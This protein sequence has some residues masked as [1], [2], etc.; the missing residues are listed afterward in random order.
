[1]LVVYTDVYN[2]IFLLV[3]FHTVVTKPCSLFSTQTNQYSSPQNLFVGNYNN[4]YN[5]PQN[6]LERALKLLHKI[7]R[8]VSLMY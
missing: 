5:V 6:I 7:K 3:T 2:L 8:N 1:M 4:Y